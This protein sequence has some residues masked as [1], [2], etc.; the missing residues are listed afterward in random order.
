MHEL[1][2]L[3]NFRGIAVDLDRL[4]VELLLDFILYVR[5]TRLACLTLLLTPVAT[6]K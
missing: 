4:D 5:I 3:Q 1:L 2:V 6:Q